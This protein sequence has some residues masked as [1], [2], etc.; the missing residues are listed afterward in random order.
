MPGFS[1]TIDPKYSARKVFLFRSRMILI[2]LSFTYCDP[3]RG[4]TSALWLDNLRIG[5]VS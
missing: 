1:T 2:G 5:L 4:D 3:H